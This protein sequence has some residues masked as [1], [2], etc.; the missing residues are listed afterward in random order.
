VDDVDLVAVVEEY[1]ASK[2]SDVEVGVEFGCESY[3]VV[4]IRDVGGGCCNSTIEDS[5]CLMD[6]CD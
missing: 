5:S 1:V 3:K 4:S 2:N 6:S